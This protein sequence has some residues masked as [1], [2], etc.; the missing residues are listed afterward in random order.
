MNDNERRCVQ[1]GKIIVG[2][3]KIKLCPRCAD[4]DL[5]AAVTTVI[6][7]TAI[8]GIVYKFRK[9]ILN[10]VKSAVKTIIKK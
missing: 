10:F 4:K 1:C 5:R 3:K 9:P 6:T 8:G 2:D 7:A